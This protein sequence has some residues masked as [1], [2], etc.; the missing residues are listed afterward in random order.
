M[1]ETLEYLT[2]NSETSQSASEITK[3]SQLNITHIGPT[4]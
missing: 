4:V 1:I 3:N 2:R